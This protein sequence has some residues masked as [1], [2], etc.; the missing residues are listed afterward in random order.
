MWA[1]SQS[2]EISSKQLRMSAS[3]IHRALSFLASTIKHCWIAS[4]VDRADLNPYEFGS[5][6]VS[7]TGSR[8]SRYSACW[9][10]STMQGIAGGLDF[11]PSALGVWVRLGGRG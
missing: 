2:C 5:A 4:A 8:A 11:F 3:R 9:A 6:V 7:A 10:L 1:T